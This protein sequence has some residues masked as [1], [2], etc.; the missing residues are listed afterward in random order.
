MKDSKL[1]PIMFAEQLSSKDPAGLIWLRQRVAWDIVGV[2][3]MNAAI[4]E[5]TNDSTSQMSDESLHN[6]ISSGLAELTTQTDDSV[7]VLVKSMRS[8]I[9]A[10][11]PCKAIEATADDISWSREQL[12]VSMTST[13]EPYHSTI[14]RY[15]ERADKVQDFMTVTC[16]GDISLIV[17]VLGD[18]V[19][20]M[21]RQ[22]DKDVNH[23]SEDAIR[24]R[25][26]KM[27]E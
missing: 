4:R 27:A 25:K 19:V 18:Q 11:R 15:R 16:G 5:L 23:E 20:P 21:I 7:P 9:G 1:L 3:K 14:V 17:G 6:L 12:N 26:S 24:N 8:A 10:V 22:P 13:R 2:A